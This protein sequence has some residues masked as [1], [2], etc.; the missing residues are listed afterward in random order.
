MHISRFLNTRYWVVCP[1]YL[2]VLWACW[3]L[4]QLHR[5]A[6]QEHTKNAS[7]FLDQSLV[8]FYSKINTCLYHIIRKALL[9]DSWCPKIFFTLHLHFPFVEAT[10]CLLLAGNQMAHITSLDA[11]DGRYVVHIVTRAIG[12]TDTGTAM[13]KNWAIE[14]DRAG[15]SV[16]VESELQTRRESRR[17]YLIGC[18]PARFVSTDQSDSKTMR[19]INFHLPIRLTLSRLNSAQL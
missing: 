14:T 13:C 6:Q 18:S 5:R 16:S 19:D 2:T 15:S 10:N 11:W 8:Q 4:G 17:S 3:P 9:V 1:W 12:P 7:H